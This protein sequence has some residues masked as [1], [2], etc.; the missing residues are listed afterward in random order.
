[1][2]INNSDQCTTKGT[3]EDHVYNKWKTFKC[4]NV[5]FATKIWT[6]ILSWDWFLHG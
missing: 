3:A 4:S 5:V 6:E 1:M 2:H